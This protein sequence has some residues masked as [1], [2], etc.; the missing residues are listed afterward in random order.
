MA[1]T[2]RTLHQH[3]VAEASPVDLRQVHDRETLD[4]LRAGMDEYVIPGAS[5]TS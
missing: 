1:L 3:F 5:A 2:F 4:Q